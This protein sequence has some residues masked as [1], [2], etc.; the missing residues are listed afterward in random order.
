MVVVRNRHVVN[1]GPDEIVAHALGCFALK[2]PIARCRGM[3]YPGLIQGDITSNS[4]EKLNGT[5]MDGYG[6]A[7]PQ[8][9]SFCLSLSKRISPSPT[10]KELFLKGGT[11]VRPFFSNLLFVS[12]VIQPQKIRGEFVETV[13]N[14]RNGVVDCR[15]APPNK[16]FSKGSELRC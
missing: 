2:G 11:K 9:R 7:P 6:L 13:L 10:P 12:R 3:L 15:Q 4:L 16:R 14:R 5:K 1:Q 8:I